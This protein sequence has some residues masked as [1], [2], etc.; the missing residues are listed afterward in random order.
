MHILVYNTSNGTV[1]LRTWGLVKPG[2][3]AIVER[4]PL[5][6]RILYI[7]RKALYACVIPADKLDVQNLPRTANRLRLTF[8][9]LEWFGDVINRGEPVQAY[10]PRGF[11]YPTLFP[12]KHAASPAAVRKHQDD[13]RRRDRLMR[14]RQ[15]IRGGTFSRA[16][17]TADQVDFVRSQA[18][19]EGSA[20]EKPAP[21]PAVVEKPATEAKAPVSTET[22]AENSPA[23]ES[24]SPVAE[25]PTAKKKKK[26]P[27]RARPS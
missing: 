18:A 27:R 7:L 20:T 4:S 26:K 21:A 14:Q 16:K 15:A 9:K 13:Q 23:A 5:L 12:R 8:R 19:G 11:L 24:A 3:F 10:E 17:I 6:D 22:P 1:T 2:T 25:K